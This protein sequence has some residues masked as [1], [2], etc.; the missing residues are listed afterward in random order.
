VQVQSHLQPPPLP[1]RGH[2]HGAVLAQA[3]P[4]RRRS[5]GSTPA[6]AA[7]A[8][9]LVGEGASSSHEAPDDSSG[10]SMVWWIV[11][12]VL[13]IAVPVVAIIGCSS[14]LARVAPNATV[15]GM[16]TSAFSGLVGREAEKAN[17]EAGVAGR[18]PS[19]LGAE[20]Q[21]RSRSAPAAAALASG[22]WPQR[23]QQ[24]PHGFSAQTGPEVTQYRQ[25][26]VPRQHSDASDEQ[27]WFDR[28]EM[29]NKRVTFAPGLGLN[30]LGAFGNADS[31]PGSPVLGVPAE[32]PRYCEPPQNFSPISAKHGK[33]EAT[34][35]YTP[36][37]QHF[38][39][40]EAGDE[41]QPKHYFIG[42]DSPPKNIA[43]HS[44]SEVQAPA[45]RPSF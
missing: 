39:G 2:L 23:T 15:S 7:G 44:G 22:P 10:T 43:I 35:A 25:W 11:V 24:I 3:V 21:R 32:T 41:E 19:G 42:D 12:L 13:A 38:N 30:S 8:L 28:Q 26:E 36:P 34:A 45:N 5:S 27:V 33:G 1:A 29:G 17:V 40:A 18:S 9:A 14:W 31:H 6:A 4:L 16:A 37:W 20:R